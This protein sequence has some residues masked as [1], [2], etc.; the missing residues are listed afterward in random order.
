MSE[1]TGTE[2]L[3]LVDEAISQTLGGDNYD[4]IFALNDLVE[5]REIVKAA[6]AA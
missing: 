5:E 4:A 6:L 3:D 2:L 1:V